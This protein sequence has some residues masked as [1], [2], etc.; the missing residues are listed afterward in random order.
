VPM[1]SL[2]GTDVS[3]VVS[4]SGLSKSHGLA[5]IRVGFLAGSAPFVKA[6]ASMRMELTKIHIN[7]VG[8]LG[9]LA[10]LEDAKY[11]TESTE[12]IRGNSALLSEIAASIEHVRQPIA[13]EYG[14]STMLDVSEAGATAQEIC[15]ALFKRKFATIPGDALG[16]VGAAD[17]LRVNFSHRE[18]DRLERFGEALADAISEARTGAHG[19]A[20]AEFYRREGTE[21]GQRIIARIEG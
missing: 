1:A 21:R 20:V 16:D 13:P 4:A 6:V 12:W 11:V 17:Y 3:H 18:R 5:A 19:N 2:E 14:F 7:F 15:V 8:Q 10:A 9:A